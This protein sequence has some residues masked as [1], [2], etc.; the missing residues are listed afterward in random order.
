MLLRLTMNG[1]EAR[2]LSQSLFLIWHLHFR[3]TLLLITFIFS[4]VWF[5]FNLKLLLRL[6]LFWKFGLCVSHEIL[7]HLTA[8]IILY[9]QYRIFLQLMR[10]HSH[11]RGKLAFLRFFHVLDTS[12]MHWGF[13]WLG[14]WSVIDSV[15]DII[16]WKWKISLIIFLPQRNFLFTLAL[17]TILHLR[18]T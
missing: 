12:L 1:D 14:F 8:G 18:R 5:F 4:G 2:R 10:N 17:S 6:L 15:Q 7:R 13:L 9:N 11:L 16:L 3:F